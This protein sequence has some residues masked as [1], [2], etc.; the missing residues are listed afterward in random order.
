ML[1]TS[2]YWHYA[3]AVTAIGAHEGFDSEE[4]VRRATDS[5]KRQD[6]FVAAQSCM[7]SLG[8]NVRDP[9][10]IQVF[11]YWTGVGADADD[12]SFILLISAHYFSDS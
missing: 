11:F 8:Q 9:A 10:A 6:Y 4:A 7:G 1:L 5:L 3:Q 12:I 2:L